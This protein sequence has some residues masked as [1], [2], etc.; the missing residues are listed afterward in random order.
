MNIEERISEIEKRL[1][2]LEK[3]EKRRKVIAI[4]KVIIYI[5]LIAALIYIGYK[6][7]NYVVNI[8]EPYKKIVETYNGADNS[9][10]DLPAI[11]RLSS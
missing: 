10:N 5:L 8:L 1:D 6:L 7:Y 4:I 11:I 9:I 2:K 3:I